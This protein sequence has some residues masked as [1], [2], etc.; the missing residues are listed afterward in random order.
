M[1]KTSNTIGWSNLYSRWLRS[2][3][4]HQFPLQLGVRFTEIPVP[5]SMSD[6]IGKNILDWWP[7]A[8]MDERRDFLSRKFDIWGWERPRKENSSHS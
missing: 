6:Q 2:L 7:T 3:E 5:S 1:L 4:H 8:K